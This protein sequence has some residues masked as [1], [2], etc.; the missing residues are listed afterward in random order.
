MTNRQWLIWQL[1]DMKDEEFVKIV[2]AP[3]AYKEAD[4]HCKIYK[5]KDGHCNRDCCADCKQ[6]QIMWLKQ[7]HESGDCR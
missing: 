1:I 5:E 3:C 6:G 7:E 4:G 2:N